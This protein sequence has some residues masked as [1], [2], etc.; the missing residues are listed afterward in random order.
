MYHLTINS[1]ISSTKSNGVFE[2]YFFFPETQSTLLTD[3]GSL[4][5]CPQWQSQ[6]L[7]APSSVVTETQY[8]SL[9]HC[10]QGLHKPEPGLE[11]QTL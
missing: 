4:A 11:P 6:K 3:S 7:G 10:S 9:P 2:A 5:R 1:T 8:L